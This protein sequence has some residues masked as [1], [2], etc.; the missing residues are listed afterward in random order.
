MRR[1]YPRA[2]RCLIAWKAFVRHTRA[3]LAMVA[4]EGQQVPSPSACFARARYTRISTGLQGLV[5]EHGVFD[6]R[7]GQTSTLYSDGITLHGPL[8]KRGARDIFRALI[9]A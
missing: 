2:S 4:M 6:E 5:L 9:F 8:Q 3:T 7:K 1:R